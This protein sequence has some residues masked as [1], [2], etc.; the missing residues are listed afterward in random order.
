M[1]TAIKI[2]AAVLVL[3]AAAGGAAWYAWHGTTGEAERDAITL[4]GNVDIRQVELA[5][6]ATDR[7]ERVLVDEG[8]RVERGRLLATLETDRLRRQVEQA[9]ARVEAQ[10]AVVAKLK[11]GPR[12]QEIEKLRA[13]VEAAEYRADNARR[14]AQRLAN[15]AER[16]LASEEQADNAQSNADAARAELRAAEEALQL[17]LAGTRAEDIE[18]AEAQLRADRA[19]LALAGQRMADAAL[20]APVDAT[21]EQRLLEPGDMA[22]PQRPVYTLART[23]PL[24]VRAWV[25]GA[26]L[27]RVRPGMRAE[28][29]TASFPDRTYA[30]WI[31]HVSPTAEFT[32]KTVQTQ[33]VRTDLVY[34]VRVIVCNPDG[35]L[36]LGM[37]ASVTIPLDPPDDPD[38]GAAEDRC[39]GS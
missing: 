27:G 14:T 34:Q 29:S 18:A 11:A 19:T 1:K 17:A 37:P 2:L 24:W 31:G 23:N 7:I 39:G 16:E 25:S 32:P 10:A 9:A 22:S 28:V 36:R 3:G 26:D 20:Y 5:F 15:L 33:E 13:E 8:D 38:P 35:E 4:H 6:N 30:G 21:V 12:R